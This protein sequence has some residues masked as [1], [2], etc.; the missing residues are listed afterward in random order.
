MLELLATSFDFDK[1]GSLLVNLLGVTSP[2]EIHSLLVLLQ[3]HVL[4]VDEDHNA[5]FIEKDIP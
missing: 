2:Q 4:L 1:Y 3:N 5:P